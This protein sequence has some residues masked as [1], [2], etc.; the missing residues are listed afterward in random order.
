MNEIIVHSHAGEIFFP[1]YEDILGQAK[2]LA[3]QINSVEVTEENVKLTKK[4]LATV[5]KRVNE[6]E[7]SRKAVKKQL[8]EPYEAFEKQVKE[9]VSIV[10]EAD[11]TVRTQVRELEEQERQAKY[12]SIR[13]LWVRRINLHPEL[14][15][16]FTHLD[17]ITNQHTNKTTPMSKIEEEMVTWLQQRSA[18]VKFLNSLE[19]ANEI[20]VEYIRCKNPVQAIEV[21]KERKR[22][23]EEVAGSKMTELAKTVTIEFDEAFLLQVH[24]FFKL[25]NIPYIKR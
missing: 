4:M 5:N 19:N 25:S 17:F 14:I 8:L 20:I 18:D 22:I 9:I 7:D 11:N 3:E 13:L 21:V 24:V 6:L 10:K 1:N 23:Q 15:D 2:E 12:E 16:L